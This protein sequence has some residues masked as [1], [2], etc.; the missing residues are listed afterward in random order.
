MTA[1]APSSESTPQRRPFW[2][3]LPLRYLLPGLLLVFGLALIAIQLLF[4]V[5]VDTQ[6][7]TEATLGRCERSGERVARF[8]E[9]DLES[10]EANREPNDLRAE[11]NHLQSEQGVKLVLLVDECARIVAAKDEKAV[12]SD[13]AALLPAATAKALRE[14]MAGGPRQILVEHD[15]AVVSGVFPL[16]RPDLALPQHGLVLILDLAEP[17]REAVM[18]ARQQAFVSGAALLLACGVLWLVLDRVITKRVT[19]ILNE[20]RSIPTGDHS[21]RPLSG[22]DELAEI[23]KALRETHAIINRQ[24]EGIRSQERRYRLMVESLPAMVYVA[25]DSVI[26]YINDT[27]LR[28]LGLTG[29]DEIIGRSPFEF[30]HPKNHETVRERTREVLKLGASAPPAEE[31]IVRKDGS[32]VEVETV[33]SVFTDS[34]GQAIQVVM[35][36]ITERKAAEA[37]REALGREITNTSE[38]EQRRIGQDLHDDICQRLAA[39]KMNMQDLEESLAEH[40]PAL[41]DEADAIVDRLTDTIRITRSLARGLSPVEIEAGGLGVAL[42]GLVRSSRELLGIECELELPDELPVL[43]PQVAT[44]FYRIAQECITNAAK[45]GQAP[46]VRVSLAETEDALVLRVSNNGKPLEASSGESQGMGLHIMR[47]RAESMDA[48]LEF[49][50]QPPDATFAVR[51]V[52]PLSAIPSTTATS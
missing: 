46:V 30:I 9:K 12:G 40:A 39:V 1:S 35:H 19:R 28:M 15:Q 20:A 21:G 44:Q 50:I 22:S 11:V 32:I 33:A 48:R 29:R 18:L 27:G 38:R 7:A 17:L 36:D 31:E 16:L 2:G 10:R 49:E 14:L 13:A 3:R 6:R 41:M 34:R 42:A 47:H 4:L 25:R 51:C 8:L 24:A 26:E 43:S 52:L 5:R 45:H 37:R 23:D